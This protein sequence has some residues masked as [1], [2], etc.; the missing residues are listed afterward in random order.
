M[1]GKERENGDGCGILGMAQVQPERGSRQLGL[2]RGGVRSGR[3]RGA[4][5]EGAG[6]GSGVPASVLDG[7]PLADDEVGPER[8]VPTGLDLAVRA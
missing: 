2:R 1:V 7:V 6:G 3:D 5:L 8:A 4:R